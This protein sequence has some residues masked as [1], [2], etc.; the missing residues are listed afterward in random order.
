MGIDPDRSRPRWV[1]PL[2]MVSV[3][4]VQAVGMAVAFILPVVARKEFGAK[5]WQTLLITATPTIFFS[6]SIFW[7][8]VFARLRFGR[9]LLLYWLIGCLPLAG[10]ALARDYWSLLVP[11]LIACVGGAGY[12]PA[13]GDLLKSLYSDRQR[14][15]IYSLVGGFSSVCGAAAGWG[16]GEWLTH[17]S[18][19]F[20][21]YMPLAAVVQLVGVLMMIALSYFTGHAAAKAARPR[22]DHNLSRVFEPVSHAKEVL[23]ADPIFAR[24]EAAYMTYG[25]GWMIAYALLPIIVTDK[26]HLEYD[27]VARSTHVA[28]WLP[29]VAMIPI[30]GWMIDRLGAVRSTGLSFLMLTLYPV[31]L[32]LATGAKSLTWITVWYGLAHAGASMGWMLGPVALAPTPAKVP[33]YVAIHATLVGIRGKL[34]QGLGVLLYWMVGGFAL[35]LAVAAGA[36]VWAAWQMWSLH[37]RMQR[38]KRAEGTTSPP[39]Q[40]DDELK[41]ESEAIPR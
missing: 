40:P 13:A 31:G 10:I 30:A 3:A 23:K 14:G 1:L 2:H 29:L 38:E 9:Y 20:R 15:R 32:A 6:L 28:Y 34:F 33:Q 39:P 21:L 27:Q 17:V 36:Y 5:D 12:H 19:A 16:I 8:D 25:I 37:G 22:P 35:P 18:Q 41:A 24:Y 7:N 26:L 4:L 11:H